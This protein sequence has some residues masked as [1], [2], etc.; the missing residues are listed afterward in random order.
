MTGNPL[1]PTPIPTLAAL[2]QAIERLTAAEPAALARTKGAVTLRNEKD[3]SL[4]ALVQQ[5]R[6]YVQAAADANVENGASIIESAGLAVRKAA[7]RAPR[8]FTANPGTVS[9]TVKLVAKSAGPRSSYEWQL[10]T[11]GGKTWLSAPVTIQARTVVTGMSAGSTVQFR[12]R[13]VTRP[14]R[15]TGARSSCC[16]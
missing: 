12:Y 8:G 4:V 9:G 7:V 14:V 1:F 5:L 2:T 11:D 16:S 6:A 3:T 13:P 10:S 15:A